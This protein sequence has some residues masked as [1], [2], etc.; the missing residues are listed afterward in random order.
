MSPTQSRPPPA[1]EIRKIANATPLRST[2]STLVPVWIPTTCQKKKRNSRKGDAAGRLLGLSLSVAAFPSGWINLNR[3]NTECAYRQNYPRP[4]AIWG[5]YHPGF[6]LRRRSCK[7]TSEGGA[8]LR[9]ETF[10]RSVV[11]KAHHVKQ[12]PSQCVGHGSGSRVTPRPPANRIQPRDARGRPGKC[13]GSSTMAEVGSTPDVAGRP[14][15]DIGIP[16]M[17]RYVLPLPAPRSQVW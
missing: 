15:G 8:G 14:C 17:A 6:G 2:P 4:Q 11:G 9:T 3:S 1:M 16:Y 13:G 10:V 5:L 12:T 7:D